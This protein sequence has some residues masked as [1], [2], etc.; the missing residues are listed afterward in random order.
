MGSVSA[1]YRVIVLITFLIYTVALIAIVLLSKRKQKKQEMT[2]NQ[3]FEKNFFAGGRGMSGLVLGILMM[4]TMTSSG[5]L[6][7]AHG[8]S[9]NFGLGM[10]VVGLAAAAG[11]FIVLAGL[12]KKLGIISRR[13][14]AISITGLLKSRYNNNRVLVSAL[15]LIFLIFLSVYSAA[16]IMGGARVFEFMTGQ[17][18]VVGLLMFGVIVG[19]YTLVG[20]MKSVATAGLFQ[21]LIMVFATLFFAIAMFVFAGKNYGGM[22]NLFRTFAGTEYEAMVASTPRL[23]ATALITMLVMILYCVIGQPHVIQGTMTYRNTQSMKQAVVVGLVA[24]TVIGVGLMLIGPMARAIDPHLEAVDFASPLLAFTVMPAPLTGI[25]LAGVTAAI[26]STIAGMMLIVS[27]AIAKEVYKDIIKPTVSEKE[28]KGVSMG[29]LAVTLVIVVI[30]SINPPDVLQLIVNFAIGGLGSALI[31]PLL[32][33]MFWRRTNEYGAITGSILGLIVY[34]V[35]Q[36]N[37]SALFGINPFIFG[38]LASILATI[39]VSLA[40]PKPPRGIIEV[41]FGKTYDKKFAL[42]RTRVK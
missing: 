2:G 19:V 23:P 39:I 12:G 17:S 31:A 38:I 16:Q 20:G 15:A 11:F 27:S 29:V 34:I 26:Q 1:S 5:T 30:I 41:W 25:L 21:G 14:E 10:S 3:S 18:Y 28:L 13:C 40:T 36:V 9:Y 6:V 22:E 35:A 32:F 24:S 8:L 4:A 7:S 42:S 33:G 37:Q